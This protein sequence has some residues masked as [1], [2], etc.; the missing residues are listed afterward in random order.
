MAF[1]QKRKKRTIKKETAKEWLLHKHFSSTNVAT[2]F[3]A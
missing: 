1:P 3:V 2:Y